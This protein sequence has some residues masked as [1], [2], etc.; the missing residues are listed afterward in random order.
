MTSD[1]SLER[2]PRSQAGPRRPPRVLL[3]EDDGAAR[4]ALARV[5][6]EMGFDVVEAEDGG[7]MLVALTAHYKG[8]RSP[9]DLDL[10]VTDVNMPVM[11]GVEAFE[12]VRAAHWKTPV[13][14]VT[15]SDTPRVGQIADRYGAT[16]LLKPL[17]L[18]VFE[19]TV[20]D[21]VPLA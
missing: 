13:L 20:R 10:I 9:D 7:R 16:V 8:G 19:R 21:L 17:D 5:L 4:R 6:R 12:G 3:A 11:S 18:D 1:P 14:I 2:V 15:A